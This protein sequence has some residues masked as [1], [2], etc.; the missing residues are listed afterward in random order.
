M[1]QRDSRAIE[2]LLRDEFSSY[3]SAQYSI[4]KSALEQ[5]SRSMTMLELNNEAILRKQLLNA[6]FAAGIGKNAQALDLSVVEWIARLDNNPLIQQQAVDFLLTI[7]QG[8]SKE[9]ANKLVQEPNLIIN[10]F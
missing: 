1:A 6:Y 4:I 3:T 10:K 8:N 5:N 9:I 7:N 2:L